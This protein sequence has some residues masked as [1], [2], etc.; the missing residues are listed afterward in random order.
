M[1]TS[2]QPLP[3]GTVTFLFSDIEGST[4]LLQELGEAYARVQDEHAAIIRRAIAESGGREIRTEGDSF[5][6]V[7][8]TALGALR[9]AVAAQRE[10]HPHDSSH[11]YPVRVRMGLHTGEGRLG[12]DDYLGIDVNR[13]ARIAAAGHGGQVLLSDTT[14]ALVARDLPE[15][16]AV[17]DLGEHRLKDL[18]LPVRIFQ[19][20][21]DGLSAE[22]P[23]LKTLDARPTNLPIQL[24]SFVGRE[25]EL[26]RVKELVGEQRLVTLTGAGGTGKTR[27]ALQVADKLLHRFSDGAFFVD[28]APIR[29]PAL[30]P[31]TAAQALGLRVDPGGDALA[32]ARAHLRERDLLLILDNFEQVAEGA[33]MIEDLL[34]AAPRLRVLITS[35]MALHIYGEQEYEVLP[36]KLPDAHRPRDELSRYEAVA[37]FVDRA[38]AVKPDFELNADTASAIAGIIARLDGLPLAIELAAS[39]VRVLTPE[40]IL[41]RL[42]Q[43]LTLLVGSARGRPERQLTM[44]GAIEWSY[45]LLEE[46]ERRLFGRLSAF[47]GGCSLEA[48]EAVCDP[49][50]LGIPVLDGLGALVEKSLL[51][52]TETQG[53]EPRFGMLETIL[54]YAAER[55]REEFDAEPTRRRLA[56]LLLAFA[57]EAE[58]HLTMEDQVRW[59]DRCERESPNLRTALRWAI[60]AGEAEIGLRTA[61]ALWRLWQQRGPLWEGRMAL[62]EL[63]ALGGSSPQVRAKALSA[64]GG[65]AWW[66]D[67]FEATQRHYEAALRLFR[68]SGDR[69]GEAGGL[70][71]LAFVT[72]WSGA[73]DAVDR[74]RA[75]GRLAHADAAEEMFRQSL[76]LAEE[77]GDRK[78]VAKAQRGIG[79]VLGVARGDPGATVP[80]FEKAAALFEELGDRW[81][82]TETVVG[83][84]NAT[85]FA[86]QRERARGHYLRGLDLMV[87]AGNRQMST[88]ILFLV[89]ALESEMA[90]HERAVRLWGAA[91]STRQVTGAVRPP[92][93]GR[94]LGDPVA[95]ARQAIGD[96]AVAQALADGGAMNLDE[97]I[98]YAHQDS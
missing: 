97:A 58:P 26:A 67:D 10:L 86:D 49:G 14:R 78:G 71:N 18:A 55:L 90:Q 60:E 79:F 46:P 59:L 30:V 89:A 81:E 38:R 27:L 22:F 3:T 91:E 45:E 34:S 65:L 42:D 80:I 13:A 69:R 1:G 82:L 83:L 17:R 63:L 61:A 50:D 62:D 77:L 21:I 54:E 84:G 29:A 72:L 88:G 23:E 96:E 75:E 15:G 25:R 16:V 92:V 95:A 66:G 39:R 52:Q 31:L 76:A 32:A 64:A 47:P 44:R 94:L 28:L 33:G 5:F 73:G 12:G 40:A 98:A 68:Q 85:R 56:E 19:L 74:A 41:S 70:Y 43:R 53:G 11:G 24:T 8:P 7:F 51:R 9:A 48:A 35:R 20:D 6:V 57:E 36:F 87:A 93:A 2:P 37:L 4:R